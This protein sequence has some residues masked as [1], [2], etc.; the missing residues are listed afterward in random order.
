VSQWLGGQRGVTG[1]IACDTLKD[2]GKQ[3]KTET[4][5]SETPGKHNTEVTLIAAR[6]AALSHKIET[7]VMASIRGQSVTTALKAFQGTDIDLIVAGCN[8]CK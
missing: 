1:Q 2:S 3:T 6:E 7:V 5:C 8:G 4:I